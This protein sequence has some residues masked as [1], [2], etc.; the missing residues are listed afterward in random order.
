MDPLLITARLR[1][2]NRS[3]TNSSRLLC[4]ILLVLLALPAISQYDNDYNE[5]Y[6]KE[7]LEEDYRNDADYENPYATDADE[8]RLQRQREEAEDRRKAE[9]MRL[10]RD[11]AERVQREREAQ[12]EA[13]LSRMSEEKRKAAKL[14]KRKDAK[15]VKKVIKAAKNANH[16]GVLGLHNMEIRIPSRSIKLGPKIKFTIPGF[17]LFQITPNKIKKAYRSRAI[18]VHPDKNRDG[19]ANEAFIAVENSSTILSD[20][21]LRKEYD[22]ALRMRRLQRR[23]A[24]SGKAGDVMGVILGAMSKGFGIFRLVLGP[25]TFPALILG[26]LII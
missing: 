9:E 11:K 19:R 26:A 7:V 21:R 25:F 5:D 17:Q 13:E 24:V 14:Q 12:F 8:E 15:I 2:N 23:Q 6:V 1:Q 16:Y 4:L 20:E 10:A 3:P 18:A 22:E